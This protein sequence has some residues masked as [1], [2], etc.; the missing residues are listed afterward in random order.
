VSRRHSLAQC[1]HSFAQWLQASMQS[2]YRLCGINSPF[3]FEFDSRVAA[4]F[5]KDIGYIPQANIRLKCWRG[6]ETLM[7]PKPPVVFSGGGDVSYKPVA[8]EGIAASPKTATA[9]G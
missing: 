1:V 5:K 6:Q 4:G 3:L 8:D 7:K 2:M 9:I